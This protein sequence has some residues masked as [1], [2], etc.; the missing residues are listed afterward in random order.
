MN[1]GLQVAS[2]SSGQCT[3]QAYG[4]PETTLLKSC[5]C[6]YPSRRSCVDFDTTLKNHGDWL[7]PK[8]YKKVLQ[9]NIYVR[10]QLLF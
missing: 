3:H 6:H 2:K 5:K 7:E 1:D 10:K 4:L 9:P 8:I